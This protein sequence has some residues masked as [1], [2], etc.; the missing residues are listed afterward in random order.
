M[1]TTI[2]G[3]MNKRVR[4]EQPAEGYRIAVDTVLLAA[5]VPAMLGER[6]LDM[7]CGVGGAMLCLAARVKDL[8]L[9]GIDI[10]SELIELCRRNI[11]LNHLQDFALAETCSVTEW[12]GSDFHHVMMNPPFHAEDKHSV[13]DNKIKRT[14]N[15]EKT[16]DLPLWL[17]SASRALNPKG[18]LTLIHRADR[19]EEII[20]AA[21]NYFNSISILPI[22]ARPGAEPKRVIFRMQKSKASNVDICESFVLYGEDNRYCVAAE[23]VIRYALPIEF[24]NPRPKSAHIER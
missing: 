4:V 10:Q 18:T 11:V 1:D 19:M 22:I 21:Q 15:A 8:L 7:G 2:D 13:S 16:G 5:S 17:G 20:A 23:A 14:A 9:T 24:T 12:T 6:V 3:L